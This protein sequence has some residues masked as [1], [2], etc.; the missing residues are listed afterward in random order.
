MLRFFEMQDISQWTVEAC[1]PPHIAT[2]IQLSEQL[3]PLLLEHHEYNQRRA[4]IRAEDILRQQKVDELDTEITGIYERLAKLFALSPE[5]PSQQQKA[6]ER[7]A[8]GRSMPR[9]S[10]ETFL[11]N[12]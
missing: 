1:T 3:L 11:R 8:G 4:A 10:S 5:Q 2:A 6:E 12:A 7:R 9:T